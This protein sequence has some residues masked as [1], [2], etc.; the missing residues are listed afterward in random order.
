MA[1]ASTSG[2]VFAWLGDVTL[3]RLC[4]AGSLSETYG[5]DYAEHALI[6]GKPL[7][8]ATGDKLIEQQWSASLKAAVCDVDQE[9]ERLKTMITSRKAYPL[10]FATGEQVG[11]FVINDLNINYSQILNGKT[12]VADVSFVLR[13][14]VE[15]D[16]AE[17]K[18]RTAKANAQADISKLPVRTQVVPTDETPKT[19]GIAEMLRDKLISITANKINHVI[20]EAHRK[21]TD[22]LRT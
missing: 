20:T 2:N 19:T 16:A 4:Y 7:L 10:A 22:A 12:M 5:I 17:T 11:L 21:A 14:F 3:S 8:Q 1:D 9:I 13:E 18:R 15:L 6:L